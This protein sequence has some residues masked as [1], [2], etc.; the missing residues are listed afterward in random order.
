MSTLTIAF[1]AFVLSI[2]GDFDGDVVGVVVEDGAEGI[3]AVEGEMEGTMLGLSLGIMLGLSLGIMLGLSLGIILGP[4]LGY[5]LRPSLGYTLGS[6]LGIEE[7]PSDGALVGDKAM[8]TASPGCSVRDLAVWPVGTT[9]GEDDGETLEAALVAGDG[10]EEIT[11]V[12]GETEGTMIGPSLGIIL[13]PS[14][15]YILGASLGYILGASLG[16]ILG[17]SLGIEEAP[18]EGALVGDKV[19]STA[20]LGC[21]VGEPVGTTLGED[22]G[23]TLEAAL[24]GVVGGAVGDAVGVCVGED[25]TE[26]VGEALGA[27]IAKSSFL[28]P[29]TRSC[30]PSS[31]N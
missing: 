30:S 18:S 12:E 11:A 17:A 14:L 8:S 22:D 21:S 31:N 23:E 28:S 25:E 27:T 9:L 24:G 29:F 20:S 19:M 4:S 7:P 6:S 2:D 26:T 1:V 15:G 3:T 13:G 10:A 16:Y 5:I